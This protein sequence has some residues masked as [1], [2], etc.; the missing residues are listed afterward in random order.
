MVLTPAGTLK[1]SSEPV[2]AKVHV[3][4]PVVVEQLP[5]AW[6]GLAL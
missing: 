5:A 1:V 6:T 3:V 4:V 2:E